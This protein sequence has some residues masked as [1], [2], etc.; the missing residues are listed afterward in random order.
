M[1]KRFF[2]KH[3]LHHDFPKF[4]WQKSFR[5]HIVHGRPDFKNHLDYI[6]KNALKHGLVKNAGD[7]IWMWVE[8]MPEPDF[9]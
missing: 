3:G 7:Y 4:Q 8:G 6:H 5:D 2:E 1:Q 9:D